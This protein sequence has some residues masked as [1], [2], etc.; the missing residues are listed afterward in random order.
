MV[1]FYNV[2]MIKNTRGLL[3]YGFFK[4]INFDNFAS[5]TLINWPVIRGIYTLT[6]LP[7]FDSAKKKAENYKFIISGSVYGVRLHVK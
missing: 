7:A 4:R 5:F 2:Y 6:F 3:G 1:K